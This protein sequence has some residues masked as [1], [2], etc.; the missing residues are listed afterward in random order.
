MFFKLILLRLGFPVSMH[1]NSTVM[2]SRYRLVFLKLWV[3]KCCPFS[4]RYFF[5][6]AF[7]SITRA[8]FEC[9]TK[10][11]K[12]PLKKQYRRVYVTLAR[13]VFCK[14]GIVKNTF[15]LQYLVGSGKLH[16]LKKWCPARLIKSNNSYEY[17][18]CNNNQ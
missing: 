2:G 1:P 4:G 5:I 12:R 15:Q 10:C 17:V 13:P 6:V 14:K 8:I 18:A 7:C 9:A 11:T 16:I 3:T